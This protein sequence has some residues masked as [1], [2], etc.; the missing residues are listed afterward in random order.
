[1]SMP[2]NESITDLDVSSMSREEY[3]LHSWK[4]SGQNISEYCK[5]NSL[6]PSTLMDWVKTSKVALLYS[7]IQTCILKDI[8]PRAYL[9]Y[10]LSQSHKLRRKEIDPVSIFQQ[11]IDKAL[12]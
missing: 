6:A 1:M 10:V 5:E 9:V 2:E 11:F 3:H 7:L 8:D 12:L 4:A